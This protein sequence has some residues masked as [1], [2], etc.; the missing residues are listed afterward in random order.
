MKPT[1]V[2]SISRRF[3]CTVVC[4]IILCCLVENSSAQ[5]SQRRRILLASGWRFQLGDP[6]D[7]TTNVTYY[8]EISDLAKLD[9]NEVGAGT[10]T[11][12]YMESI[13]V[14]PIATHAGENVSFVLTNYDD[15]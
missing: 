5:S 15:S 9:S 8:P 13:R 4:F 11:E 12:S 14:D 10:N 2:M 1:S 3:H 7:V 6:A